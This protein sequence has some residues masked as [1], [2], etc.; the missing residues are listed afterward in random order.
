MYEKEIKELYKK[1]PTSVCKSDC[2]KCCR[3][4]IQFS[5]SE[6]KNMGGY[7]WKGQCIHLHDGKCS[8][9]DRRPLV[10]RIFGTSEMLICENCTPDKYLSEEE[11]AKII[12]EYTI[13]RNQEMKEV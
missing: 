9:Y 7:R 12:R 13:Y 5:P 10:C 4:M 2:S 11:T 6:E 1:I 8:I 3:D